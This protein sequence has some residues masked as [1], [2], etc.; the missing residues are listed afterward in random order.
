MKDRHELL[1]EAIGGVFD[2]EEHAYH[3]AS[4]FSWILPIVV[5]CGGFIDLIVIVVYMKFVHPWKAIISEVK[6]S[7][8]D[9]ELIEVVKVDDKIIM[10]KTEKHDLD[11]KVD[12]EDQMIDQVNSSIDQIRYNMVDY[13][14]IGF[15]YC[16]G[17][18]EQVESGFLL[19]KMFNKK[20]HRS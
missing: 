16:S 11:V 18:I 14:N 12:L 7:K 9:V 8:T 4:K 5:L 3:L 15:F 1:L 13:H 19:I 6:V 17:H 10:N 2:E 20:R